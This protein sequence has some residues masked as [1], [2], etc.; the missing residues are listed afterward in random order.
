MRV[1]YHYAAI[2]QSYE[3]RL[4]G[5]FFGR[6]KYGGIFFDWITNFP[7][8]NQPIGVGVLTKYSISG[9]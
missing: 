1:I 7:A 6:G 2:E 5:F 3:S 9:Y 4:C 8:N